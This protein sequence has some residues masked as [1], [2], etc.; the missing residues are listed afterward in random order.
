KTTFIS[1]L[2]RFYEPTAGRILIDGV[3]MQDRSLSWLQSE[4]GI[5]LQDPHLFSGTVME[6]IRYG[7]L[8]AT[9]EQVLEAARL[10]G[11]DPFIEK[12]KGGFLFEV[13]E[14]GSRLSA[15]ER[16][17]V[18]FARALLK[19][20]SVLVMDE[21]TSHIDT[22]TEHHI[23]KGLARILENRTCVVIAHRL[24]TIENADRILVVHAGEIV[25]EGNHAELMALGG[26]YHKLHAHQSLTASNESW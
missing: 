8:E 19:D 23:Q 14:G 4:F 5:V 7:R 9:D 10:V 2:C 24:S 12:L 6:N 16:Q 1:L 26:R 15:G 11:A 25:E 17:L 3:P 22:E 18:S 13:G 20:P 21:A